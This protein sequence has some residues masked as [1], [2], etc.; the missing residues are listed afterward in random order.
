MR[1]A[2]IGAS[3][4]MPLL[5]R[6]L[7]NPETFIV[8]Q[9]CRH[10][11]TQSA[12]IALSRSVSRPRWRPALRRCPP[13]D[14][15]PLGPKTQGVTRDLDDIA[16]RKGGSKTHLR[17]RIDDV[18]EVI[19]PELLEVKTTDALVNPRRGCMDGH[20]RSKQKPYK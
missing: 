15:L 7:Y 16:A 8:R 12:E 17:I 20:G 4:S 19:V 10:F 2:T 18:H 9:A 3:L 13:D 11:Q 6:N 14:R 1:G 5:G